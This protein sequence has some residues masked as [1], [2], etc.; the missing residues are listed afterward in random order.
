MHCSFLLPMQAFIVALAVTS[1]SAAAEERDRPAALAVPANQAESQPYDAGSLR[2]IAS[3]ENTGGTFAVLELHEAGGYLTPPHVHPGMDESFYVLEG[4]LQ[5]HMQ[6]RT[7]TLGAGSYVFIPRGTP[8]AQGSADKNPVRLLATFTP[9]GFD[10]FFLDRVQLART[11]QRTDPEFQG[12][13]LDIVRRYPQWLKP[14]E[15]PAVP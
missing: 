5:L 4:T 11:T 10:G 12:R 1:G 8:H 7:Q 6:G 15:L 3:S 14:A 9:G 13:M 2:V